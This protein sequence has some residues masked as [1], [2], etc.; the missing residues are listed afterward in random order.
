MWKCSELSFSVRPP[1]AVCVTLV[2]CLPA[3]PQHAV[4]SSELHHGEGGEHPAVQPLAPTHPH[5]TLTDRTRIRIRPRTGS[6]PPS[7]RN[8]WTE[9]QNA[10]LDW[11]DAPLCQD[12]RVQTKLRRRETKWQNDGIQNWFWLYLICLHF[13]GFQSFKAVLLLYKKRWSIAIIKKSE[14][15]KKYNKGL[16]VYCCK[17][18]SSHRFDSHAA[19]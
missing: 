1:A 13:L 10:A 17:P 4:C 11:T 3:V 16:F 15:T 18:A 19:V 6:R 2:V 8:S 9:T 14:K 7:D 12:E 5:L